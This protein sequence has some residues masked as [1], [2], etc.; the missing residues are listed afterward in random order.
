MRSRLLPLVISAGLFAVVANAG[1]TPDVVY[2]KDGQVWAASYDG[3]KKVQI[4][5]GDAW[6]NAAAV[7]TSGGIVAAKKEPGKIAQLTQFAIWNAD[8]TVK[9]QGPASPGMNFSGSLAAPLGLEPT[10]G[11]TGLIFGF[12]NYVY[13]SPTGYGILPSATRSTPPSIYTNNTLRRPSLI[14]GDSGSSIYVE[15]AAGNL[16]GPFVPW[17]ALDVASPLQYQAVK[18]SDDGQEEGHGQGEAQADEGR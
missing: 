2:I 6:W 3:G 7:S 12:S 9:D 13:G 4:S 16:T 10:P 15:A 5:D 18:T 1:A 8:G 17:S 14:G 11:N